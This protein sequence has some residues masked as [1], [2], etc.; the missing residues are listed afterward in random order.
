MSRL[1]LSFFLLIVFLLI[2]NCSKDEPYKPDSLGEQKGTIVFKVT[3]P[4]KGQVAKI[5]DVEEV[6]S[7]TAY[8]NSESGTEISHVDLRHEDSRGKV[9]ISVAAGNNYK[10]VLAVHLASNDR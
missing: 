1:S 5:A 3:W 9:E 8:V 7:I 6:S 2:G 10:V 4:S